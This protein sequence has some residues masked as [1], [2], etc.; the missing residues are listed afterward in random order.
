MSVF[1]TYNSIIEKYIANNSEVFFDNPMK[2]QAIN[3]T[4]QELLEEYDIPE[5]VIRSTI[6]F[7]ALGVAAKPSDYFKMSKLWD[8]DTNGIEQSVYDYI[9]PYKADSL[10]STAAYYWTEDYSVADAARKLKC[11]PINAGTLQIRY[12]KTPGTVD[13][14]DTTDSGL[15]S[16]WDK[17]VA[18]GAAKA[19]LYNA[20]R[21]DEADRMEKEYLKKKIS[22]YLAVKNPGG[23]KEAARL[24]SVYERKSLLGGF[25]SSNYDNNL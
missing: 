12:I 18:F 23:V 15:S 8:V 11:W 7:S 3:D 20:G 25:S 9:D 17:T 21:F 24:K 19:L 1:S 4:V 2:A 14:T 6:T 22:T 5:M 13:T 10:A 16:R